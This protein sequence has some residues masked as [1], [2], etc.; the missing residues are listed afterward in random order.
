[1]AWTLIF[2]LWVLSAMADVVLKGFVAS[3]KHLWTWTLVKDAFVVL[4]FVGTIIVAQIGILNN[5]YCLSG[6]M[7]LRSSAHLDIGPQSQADWVAGWPLW[8]ATPLSALVVIMVLIFTVGK[9][10]EDSRTL[11]SRSEGER[12]LDLLSLAQLREDLVRDK[13][14]RE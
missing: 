5:C 1:M 3:A 10:G 12:H 11:L 4:W 7:D 14:L 9:D 8:I 6:Y 2:M 13:E